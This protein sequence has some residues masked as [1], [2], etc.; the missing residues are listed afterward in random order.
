MVWLDKSCTQKWD[1]AYT[2][3]TSQAGY[4]MQFSHWTPALVSISMWCMGWTSV[5]LGPP[6]CKACF[7]NSSLSSRG[8]KLGPGLTARLA[9]CS[10]HLCTCNNNYLMSSSKHRSLPSGSLQLLKFIL[11]IFWNLLNWG[12]QF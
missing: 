2:Q 3:C 5:N 8:H 6:L 1:T 10:T 7:Q 12:I 4:R 9:N 11:N